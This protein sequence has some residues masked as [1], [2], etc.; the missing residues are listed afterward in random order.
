[1]KSFGSAIGPRL[2]PAQIYISILPF[3]TLILSHCHDLYPH[4]LH[5]KHVGNDDD[6]PAIQELKQATVEGNYVATI[7]SGPEES[8][9]LK[10][11]EL[12]LDPG[13]AREIFSVSLDSE[14]LENRDDYQ[15][16]KK[17][18]VTI[19]RDG[20]VIAV[21]RWRCDVFNIE[22]PS[23]L[24]LIPSHEDA[25]ITCLQ[26]SPNCER[27]V[28]GHRDGHL[29]EWDLSSGR[30]SRTFQGALGTTLDQSW[31]V[32]WAMY[33][34]GHGDIIVSNNT[35]DTFEGETWMLS[36]IRVWRRDG[37]CSCSLTVDSSSMVNFLIFGT[38][39]C[40]G[41]YDKDR[42][43]LY[44]REILTEEIKFKSSEL[45]IPPQ[46]RDKYA[47]SYCNCL[48]SSADGRLVICWDDIWLCVWDCWEKK[49]L[50]T[51]VGHSGYIEVIAFIGNPS[52]YQFVS[53]S[54]D[55]TIRLWNLQ[56][57]LWGDLD[58]TG[59]EITSWSIKQVQGTH[60]II[61]SEGEILFYPTKSY[62]FRH[63]LN[64]VIIGKHVELDLTH[65]VY[66][67]EWT[68]C[69]EPISMDELTSRPAGVSLSGRR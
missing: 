23:S 2:N 55:G 6:E 21:G 69:R 65:F 5:V 24:S 7:A 67:K 19:S 9:T 39:P 22:R 52:T 16:P 62:P 36:K 38:T 14:I 68:K 48:A 46:I 41:Y 11:F 58:T 47:V 64:T 12:V 29:H 18:P 66:G 27:I 43:N 10:A 56:P 63:P 54:D 60:W 13:S 31:I 28:A 57:V 30:S 50:A 26:I 53:I 35:T 15:F 37:S 49:I 51:L 1:M 4:I 59:K 34:D 45:N 20:N 8:F 61:N 3:S 40:I 42:S 44:I 17:Y 32:S 33:M 25:E